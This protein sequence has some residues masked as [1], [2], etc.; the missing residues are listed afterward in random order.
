MKVIAAADMKEEIYENLKKCG[1]DIL[2]TAALTSVLPGLWHHADMQLAVIDKNV[3][4]EP[5]MYDYYKDFVISAGYVPVRGKSVLKSNYPK[6]VAYNIT[7]VS[8]CI[9]HNIKY[10]DS[11]VLRVGEKKRLI[12]IS[13]GYSGCSTC[14]IGENSVITSD[15]SVYRAVKSIG[16]DCLLISPGNI[17]LKGF[18]Y[19]FIG[20]A[21]FFVKNTLYIFGNLSTH[22][23]CDEIKKFCQKHGTKITELC[24]GTI[25]DYG[26]VITF[27]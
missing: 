22:P 6:D 16:E 9:M 12:D 27:D 5:T 7:V 4:C 21:T 14:C 23:E 15:V 19:G 17:Q 20:G 26:S 3:V 2:K 18:D 13:Q 1:F 24:E 8:D 25:T 11:E 10:T